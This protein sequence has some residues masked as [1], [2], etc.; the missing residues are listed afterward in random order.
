MD[1]KMGDLWAYK[2]HHYRS[3]Y[4]IVLLQESCEIIQFKSGHPVEGQLNK[5]LNLF[6]INLKHFLNPY[7][8]SMLNELYFRLVFICWWPFGV[9]SYV[10]RKLL[11][12]FPLPVTRCC[13]FGPIIKGLSSVKTPPQQKLSNK[14]YIAVIF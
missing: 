13:C 5:F 1:I 3:N 12:S 14:L 10:S 6:K 11:L 7:R 8:E 2:N 9:M 4:H